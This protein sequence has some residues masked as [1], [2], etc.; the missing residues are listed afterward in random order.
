LHRFELII[1]VVLLGVVKISVAAVEA[2]R[3]RE[4][5][6][7]TQFTTKID[8]VLSFT[9]SPLMLMYP[10]CKFFLFESY[11]MMTKLRVWVL[12]LQMTMIFLFLRK[13]NQYFVCNFGYYYL[14]ETKSNNQLVRTN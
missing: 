9:P 5:Q 4:R 12:C 6:D 10:F 8:C 13:K 7:E 3:K 11:P 2:L 1:V 14:F